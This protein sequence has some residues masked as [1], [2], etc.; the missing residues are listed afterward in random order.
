M[1]ETKQV[2]RE[3]E[4]E[5]VLYR[6]TAECEKEAVVVEQMNECEDV[7]LEVKVDNPSDR[8]HGFSDEEVAAGKALRYSAHGRAP[9]QWTML[10]VA[11]TDDAPPSEVV[12]P[13]EQAI[14]EPLADSANPNNEPLV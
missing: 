8:L 9:G 13:A 3:L 7:L 2:F 11:E 14:A 1:G 5:V 6:A 4:G 10:I 12:P